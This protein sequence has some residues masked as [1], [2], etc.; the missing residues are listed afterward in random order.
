MGPH[1]ET[2]RKKMFEDAFL[3]DLGLILDG[4]V[5]R[6]GRASVTARKVLGKSS[7]AAVANV[8]H[9]TFCFGEI[10]W[11]IHRVLVEREVNRR[12]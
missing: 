10:N 6:L 4:N 7:E 3:G 11:Q 5:G 8:V 2:A 12:F 1:L 9:I